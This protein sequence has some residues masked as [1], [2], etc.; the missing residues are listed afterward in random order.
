MHFLD[1]N[2]RTAYAITSRFLNANH[3]QITASQQEIIDFCVASEN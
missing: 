3:Y 2:K 1:G